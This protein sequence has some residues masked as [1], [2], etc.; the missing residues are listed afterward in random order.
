MFPVKSSK[1]ISNLFK[2]HLI[3][4]CITPAN[5]AYFANGIIKSAGIT[6]DSAG[7]M[8]AF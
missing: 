8:G 6:S 4:I 1:N 2:F 5:S 7:I 3:A